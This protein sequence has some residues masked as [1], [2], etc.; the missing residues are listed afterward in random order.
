[1]HTSVRKPGRRQ[2]FLPEIYAFDGLHDP[3]D[4][5]SYFQ[6]LYNCVLGQGE[7]EEGHGYWEPAVALISLVQAYPQAFDE[8]FVVKIRQRWLSTNKALL[9]ELCDAYLDGA[10]RGPGNAL[11]R[12]GNLCR[13]ARLFQTHCRDAGAVIKKYPAPTASIA[14]V[15]PDNTR[16][17]WIEWFQRAV[18]F[19]TM[20][21]E[22]FPSEKRGFVGVVHP[23]TPVLARLAPPL[24]PT[25][26]SPDELDHQRDV[27]PYLAFVAYVAKECLR[28]LLLSLRAAISE[29]DIPEG[30]LRKTFL[31]C[32]IQGSSGLE[33]EAM[34]HLID[35]VQRKSEKPS[36]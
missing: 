7:D 20:R 6:Y 24:P 15:N 33:F 10:H 16:K 14:G 17:H 34:E 32:G 1:M 31:A 21:E 11:L 2:L 5:T 19:R 30:P 22:A 28:K 9:R 18:D 29:T 36:T 3:H 26:A 4:S 27:L 8:P 13:D 35:W 12:L 25:K 23:L